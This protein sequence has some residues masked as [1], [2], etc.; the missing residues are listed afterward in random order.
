MLKGRRLVLAGAAGLGL[1]MSLLAAP[2][3]ALAD[4]NCVTLAN[5]SVSCNV[6]VS[7]PG[8]PGGGGTP[9]PVDDSGPGGFTPGPTA[10]HYDG[11]QGGVAADVPCSANDG[12]WSPSGQ[13]YTK[14]VDP[15]SPPPAGKDASVGAWYTCVP[16]GTNCG[17]AAVP[18]DCVG[19][20]FWSDVPP[21]GINRYTPA[22][23]A[24]ALA[25]TFV[26]AG[27]NIGM[28]PAEKVHT[29]DPVG[30]AAYRRT[31]VGIPVWLWVNQP[32]PATWGPMGKTATLGGVTVTA[33]ASVQT[34][35]WSSG[36]GQT[37]N[38]GLGTPFDQAAMGDQL[39]V[40]SPNCG[41]RYQ[42][43]SGSGTFTVTATT[44]WVVQWSG[45]G[46]SGTIAMPTTS[47]STQVHV[48]ELQSVNT[49]Q[50]GDTYQH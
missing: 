2:F 27:V 12:W 47:S 13:C 11:S 45:G 37:V 36:D 38:C 46:Q 17:T 6:G 15:Q 41:F 10:C 7:D 8:S 49:I 18:R 48:G 16:V 35:T 19:A 4:N 23:A 26:L 43:T 30:T 32:T 1:L 31:W 14:I 3:A 28:A 9:T 29:D 22:Q 50:S 40:D 42:D 20:T 44:A 5:G 24:G 34:L 25:K 39:A 33:T 21:P